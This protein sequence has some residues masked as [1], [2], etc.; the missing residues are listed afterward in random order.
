MDLSAPFAGS[1]GPLLTSGHVAADSVALGVLI[2]GAAAVTLVHL[3]LVRRL[4]QVAG[5]CRDLEDV[6]RPGPGERSEARA[7]NFSE[8]MSGSGVATAWVEFMRRRNRFDLASPDE[9]A[10]VRFSDCLEQ[11]SLLPGGTRGGLL[12][13]LPA[14]LLGLGFTACFGA[15]AN[16]LAQV[17]PGAQIPNLVG[18]AL[19]GAFWGIVLATVAA[20][21]ASIVRSTNRTLVDRVSALVERAYPMISPEEITLLTA[22]AQLH[23]REQNSELLRRIRRELRDSVTASLGRIEVAASDAADHANDEQRKTLEDV[24]RDLASAFHYRLEDQLGALRESM[25]DSNSTSRP[26]DSGEPTPEPE[27]ATQATESANEAADP[28]GDPREQGN[29]VASILR[30]APDRTDQ[31]RRE[32]RREEGPGEVGADVTEEVAQMHEEMVESVLRTRASKNDPGSSAAADAS[33][34]SGEDPGEDEKSGY[35]ALLHRYEAPRFSLDELSPELRT[36]DT[37]AAIERARNAGVTPAGSLDESLDETGDAAVL[38]PTPTLYELPPADSEE[39][40]P[41]QDPEEDEPERECADERRLRLAQF[42][43]RR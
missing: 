6:C 3:P 10:P 9:A 17:Q 11:R 21:S 27:A 12:E 8:R 39:N 1:L 38:P 22:D 4:T 2:V 19:R 36:F 15:L 26:T 28:A 25:N 33:A 18:L 41:V 34:A 24:T 32:P 16:G 42:L 29:G 20:V 40:E 7:R 13:A 5:L 23:S 37:D 35:S 31:D 43:R 30:Q 14:L